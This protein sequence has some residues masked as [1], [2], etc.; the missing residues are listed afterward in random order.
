MKK[1]K[2]LLLYL[3]LIIGIICSISCRLAQGPVIVN[4]LSIEVFG[5]IVF[6]D[7][8]ITSG[9]LPSGRVIWL[10]H[11]KSKMASLIVRNSDKKILFEVEKEQLLLWQSDGEKPFVL[12]IVETGVRKISKDEIVKYNRGD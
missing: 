10:G 9:N 1:I 7:G 8:H 4:N 12:L 6:E 11:D 2:Y 3:C 5:E